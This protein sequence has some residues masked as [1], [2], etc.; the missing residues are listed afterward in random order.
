MTLLHGLVQDQQPTIDSIEDS[1]HHSKEQVQSAQRDLRQAKEYASS[2]RALSTIPY[3][4]GA[5]AAG[6]FYL[7]WT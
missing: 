2:L 4:I 3:L 6:L 7:L 1:I 5:G